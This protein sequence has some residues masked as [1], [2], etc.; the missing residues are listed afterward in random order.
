MTKVFNIK[1]VKE[2]R[3]LL[4]HSMPKAEVLLWMRLKGKQIYGYKFRRQYSVGPYI[5]DFYCPKMKL[6]IEI[7]GPTHFKPGAKLKDD[8]RQKYIESFGILFLRFLNN[9]IYENLD[10][11]IKRIGDYILDFEDGIKV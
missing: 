1:S 6:A 8:R 10:G 5:V 4:R 3:K 7:D 9:D 11:V 2:R